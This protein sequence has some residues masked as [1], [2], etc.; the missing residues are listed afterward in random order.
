M[1]PEIV[2]GTAGFGMD[3]TAFQ[4]ADSV[5]SLLKT[6]QQLGVSRLDTGA[7]YPPLS[8]GRSEQLIGEAREL[9]RD[10]IVDTKV[11][12]DTQTDGSGDLTSDAIAK[13]IDASLQRLQ[14]PEGVNVLYIH[15]ADPSTALEEQIQGFAKQIAVG[16][17]NAW[18]VSNVPPPVLERMLQLCEENGW[19]KPSCY[20]GTYNVISRGMETRLLPILRAHKVK[21]VAFWA[22]AT[23]F[24]N[25]KFVNGQS[26]GTRMADDNPLGQHFQ[27]MY[28]SEDVLSAVK[29]FDAETRAHGLSPL[30]VA[31][32]W[33]FYH[34]VLTDDDSVLLGASKTEQVVESVAFVRKGPLS[35]KVL[36]LVEGLW[37]SV[38]GSRSDVI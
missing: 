23:G 5:K 14:R 8:P 31:V 18:G 36:P 35:G 13:S 15:R 22:L 19:P 10:F 29:K 25:G 24:L 3:K 12:T 33:I 6:L 32:R 1:A 27:T 28:G 17:C 34:S 4:D 11:F 2:F 9:S 16:H 26:A 37:E 7:R 38:K 20:Q 21:F 30:E